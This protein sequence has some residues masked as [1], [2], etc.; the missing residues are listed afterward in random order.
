MGQ[1][2]IRLLRKYNA[3]ITIIGVDTDELRGNT[4]KDRYGIDI[5]HHVSEALA[6]KPDAV[7]V[8]T[9]PLSHGGIV[10]AALLHDCN[11]FVEINLV[12]DSYVENM[13]LANKRGLVLFLSSTMKYRKEIQ[14]ITGKVHGADAGVNY[15][16]HVGQYLP[17]WHPWEN[18]KDF[19]VSDIR[20]NGCREI[21]AIELPWILDA[22]GEIANVD[23]SRGKMSGLDLPY[24][25]NYMIFVEHAN[26][27]KGCFCV[28]VVSQKAVRTL[29]IFGEALHI[30]WDGAANSLF[31]YDIGK[32]ATEQISFYANAESDSMYNNTIVEDAYASEIENFFDVIAGVAE[33]LHSFAQDLRVLSAIDGIEGKAVSV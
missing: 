20:T 2:R 32:Q 18:Y 29:E 7:F 26:G 30:H 21:M 5:R 3:D 16:Y 33:P 25:D 31:W 11:V 8:S 14:F 24:P 17:D 6:L 12:A 15:I 13:E 28:D 10:K 22:F 27:S 23:V 9:S 1:R 4:S 19:F